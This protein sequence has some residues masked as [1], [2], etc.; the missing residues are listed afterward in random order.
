MLEGINSRITEAKEHISDPED[1]GRKHCRKTEYKEKKKEYVL[2]E[3]YLHTYT[4]Y[5]LDYEFFG[6]FLCFLLCF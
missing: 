1:S 4:L 6:G 3:V 5:R 2:L